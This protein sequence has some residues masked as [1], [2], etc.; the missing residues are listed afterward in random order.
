MFI[1]TGK[2]EDSSCQDIVAFFSDVGLLGNC[3]SKSTEP[4]LHSLVT[5]SDLSEMSGNETILASDTYG[6]RSLSNRKNSNDSEVMDSI[7][8]SD[9]KQ[10][11]HKTSTQST[12]AIVFR[13]NRISP[14]ES[15][16]SWESEGNIGL[17]DNG[18]HLNPTQEDLKQPQSKSCVIL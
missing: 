5:V 17:A 8:H 13:R 14:V 18:Q 7:Q 16:S 2:A 12:R 6:N 11:K 3:Y 10:M 9:D 15:V 1:G 4:E